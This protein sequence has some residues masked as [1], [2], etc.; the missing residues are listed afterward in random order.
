MTDCKRIASDMPRSFCSVCIVLCGPSG[1]GK[2]TIGKKLA[3]ILCIAYEEGDEYH[4]DAN[5]CK[6]SQG[7]PLSDADRIPWLTR[8]REEVI[9]A[10]K[11][12][13]RNVVLACSALKKIYRDI[14]C[15][16][17]QRF[18]AGGGNVQRGHTVVSSFSSKFNNVFFV[19]L[20]GSIDLIARALVMRKNH[21][22]PPSLLRS[23]FSI[24][25]PLQLPN[26]GES[27]E[28]TEVGMNIDLD[29]LS[30][31]NAV[32]D[33]IKKRILK[34]YRSSF[35]SFDSAAAKGNL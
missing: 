18:K 6:M 29:R 20:T 35:F 16:S 5:I 12:K 25:E 30:D 26:D 9:L 4:S 11:N 19:M 32:V 17:N 22:M 14:L 33:V 2:T 13:G 7:I 3:E 10:Y 1:S 34:D 8:L 15:G 27:Y 31:T 24:L 28:A 21:F 23:Q